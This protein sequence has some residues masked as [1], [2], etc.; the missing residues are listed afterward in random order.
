MSRD[1]QTYSVIFIENGKLVIEQLYGREA[2]TG[3]LRAVS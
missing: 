1:K 2:V 3:A